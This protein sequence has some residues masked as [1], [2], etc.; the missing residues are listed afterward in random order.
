[1]IGKPLSAHVSTA[2]VILASGAL[3]A[4]TSSDQ[5]WQVIPRTISLEEVPADLESVV[6]PAEGPH[7]LLDLTRLEPAGSGPQGGRSRFRGGV[8]P[9]FA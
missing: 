7:C 1:M 5:L 9:A 6:L 8:D 3:Y 2:A 4:Q